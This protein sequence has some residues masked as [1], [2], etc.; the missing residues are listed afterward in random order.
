MSVV[1]VPARP[2]CFSVCMKMRKKCPGKN[3]LLVFRWSDYVLPVELLHHRVYVCSSNSH[4]C[5]KCCRFTPV[6][7]NLLTLNLYSCLFFLKALFGLIS[8]GL[9]FICL[10]NLFC[11]K[12]TIRN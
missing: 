3:E 6:I 12:A 7:F 11:R 2:R 4:W 1:Q 8:F 5:C 9:C 10:V